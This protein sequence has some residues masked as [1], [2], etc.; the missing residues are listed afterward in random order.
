[1]GKYN[2]I[3]VHPNTVYYVF[4][5]NT[6]SLMAPKATIVSSFETLVFWPLQFLACLND[7]SFGLWLIQIEWFSISVR[8]HNYT[9][10]THILG[11]DLFINFH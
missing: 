4:N 9:C 10:Y 8:E 5:Y 7:W 3:I 6:S 11:G 2:V 1:M